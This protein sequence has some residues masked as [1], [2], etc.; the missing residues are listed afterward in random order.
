MRRSLIVFALVILPACR[1]T[2]IAFWKPVGRP[3]ATE[4]AVETR[5]GISYY[6]GPGVDPGKHQLDVGG[7]RIL[8]D[9]EDIRGVVGICG[10]YRIPEGKAE[11]ELGGSAPDAFRFDEIAPVRGNGVT[12]GFLADAPGIPLK[13]NVFGPAFGNDPYVRWAAS[14][15]HHVRPGLPP[16]LLVSAEKDLPLLPAM[17]RDMHEALQR[18]GVESRHITIERRNHSSVLF[19][20]AEPGDPLARAI[21]EFVHGH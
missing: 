6:D 2:D 9:G 17:A 15:L 18:V 4:Y 8:I 1:V 12:K 21:V 7:G 3:D 20:T 16:F 19:K 10:V 5:R 13:V 14:P 11:V